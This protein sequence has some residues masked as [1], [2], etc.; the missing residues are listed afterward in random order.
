MTAPLV[1]EPGLVTPEWI[2]EVLCDAGA[3]APDS[4]VTS[5]TWQAIGTGQVGDN[6][7][8]ALEYRGVPG[9]ATIVCKFGSRDPSSA[10]AG[11]SLGL[12]ETEVAF[13]KELAPTV[14]VGCPR[15]YFAAVEPGTADAVVVME[16]LAPAEQGDQIAGCS[17][18]QAEIAVD[19]A[20]RLHG[21]RWGDPKLAELGWLARNENTGL[22]AAMPLVW[23]PFVERYKGSLDQ[24]TVD[25][26]SELATLV[27]AVDARRSGARTATHYDFRLDNMLFGTVPGGRP[28]TVVDWQT[29]QLG[30]GV[31][32]VAYFLGNAFE[33]EVRRACEREL[34]ARYHTALVDDYGIDDYPLEQCW[35]DYVTFSYASLVMAVFASMLVGRTDR[36]DAMFMAMANRS[37]QMA[38]DL[39]APSVIR[40]SE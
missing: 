34:V 11:V 32:D 3:I 29:V 31:R 24:V 6:V 30:P 9:P 7:R 22:G 25:A 39:D 40:G 35:T 15:C 17:L 36:G 18:V 8:Y 19:E 33:P 38:A 5:I 28:L 2:T 14:D 20:A 13:Y 26:G 1:A 27:S 37:A 10:A 16:D 23:D 21:P 12:Y 4:A